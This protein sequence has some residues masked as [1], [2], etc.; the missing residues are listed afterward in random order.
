[1]ATTIRL[2]ETGIQIVPSNGIMVFLSGG[3][4]L[5]GCLNDVPKKDG[6]GKKMVFF[7]G[8]C[9]GAMPFVFSNIGLAVHAVGQVRNAKNNARFFNGNNWIGIMKN[10]ELTI[11][12]KPIKQLL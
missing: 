12:N 5:S 7:R 9:A 10:A 2:T 1:M 8:N 6:G 3:K 11:F 4:P